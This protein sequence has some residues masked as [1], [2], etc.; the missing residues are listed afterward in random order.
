MANK[1]GAAQSRDKIPVE[2]IHKKLALAAAAAAFQ[3]L[4]T[5][6]VLVRDAKAYF[7]PA[8]TAPDLVKTYPV[9][10]RLP[11]RYILSPSYSISAN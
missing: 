8:P 7:S 1:E 10:P 9:R 2:P 6:A 4:V 11:V 5:A 3:G